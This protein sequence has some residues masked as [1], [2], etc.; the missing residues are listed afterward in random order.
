MNQSDLA[1][2]VSNQD[3][4]LIITLQLTKKS[5]KVGYLRGQWGIRFF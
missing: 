3:S 2:N 4:Q 5:F 1:M